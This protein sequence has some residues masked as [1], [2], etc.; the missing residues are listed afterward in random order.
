MKFLRKSISVWKDVKAKTGFR[1]FL[2]FLIFVAISA[3][4]WL[5]LALNDNIQEDLDVRVEIFNVPDSVN[6]ITDPP[7]SIH[8][9]VRDK[10]TNILRNGVFSKP[11]IHLNFREYGNDGS[12]KV[13][14]GEMTA[15]LKKVFGQS[16]S[17][18]SSSVESLNNTYTTLPGKRVPVE[19]AMDITPAVGKII[20]GKPKVEPS[21][22][23]VFGTRE[24]LDSISRVVTDRLRSQNLDDSKQFTVKIKKIPG[25][26]IEPSEVKVTVNV[27]QLVRKEARVNIRIDNLPE[28]ED[29]LLFPSTARVEYY[30]PMSKFGNSDDNFDVRVDYR[31]LAAGTK[32]LPLHLGRYGNEMINVRLLDQNV[33]YTLVKN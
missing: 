32:T 11:A 4:F 10:G 19:V 25:V 24:S 28:G 23:L 2:T 15:A 26:K 29:L 21:G 30:V 27:D 14:R 3:L 1:K 8:V 7:A 33:E 17:I 18:I 9:L 20:T 16:A 13:N 5:I 31:D 22:V 6:F 12:F